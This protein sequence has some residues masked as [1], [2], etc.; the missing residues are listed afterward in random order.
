M[1]TKC[2]YNRRYSTMPR[3]FTQENVVPAIYSETPRRGD[4]KKVYEAQKSHSVKGDWIKLVKMDWKNVG[5]NLD[6]A[7][8]QSGSKADFLLKVRWAIH[9]YVLFL[10]LQR[11]KLHD[12]TQTKQT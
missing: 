1:A 7:E 5:M 12:E 2:N 10:L 9:K 3:Y 6:E 4:I 8:L 11:S